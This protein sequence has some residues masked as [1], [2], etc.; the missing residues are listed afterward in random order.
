MRILYSTDA[1]V[2]R[3]KPLA[4][5]I[6]KNE[7]DLK[8][9]ISFAGANQTALIP[10][11]AGTSLAGQCVGNGIVV[12]VSRNFTQ[13]LELNIEEKWVR[14]QPGVIRDELNLYLKPH[15]LMFGPNTS[16]SNRC[17]IGGMVG[18]NSCGSTSIAYGNTRDHLIS[19]KTILSDGSEATFESIDSAS[20]Q[21]KSNQESLEGQLY[22]VVNKMLSE[23]DVCN[24][25]IKEFPKKEVR[26][27]NT[28]YALDELL[29]CELFA[30]SKEQF[31]F[32]KLLAGSEG[33]LAFTTEIKINLVPLPP[34]ISGLICIHFD[35]VDEALQANK[36]AVNHNPQA[37]ELMDR[38]ILDCTIGHIQYEKYRFFLE[39]EPEAILAVELAANTESELEN[40]CNA[41]VEELEEADLG[42]LYPIL[43]EDDI[44]KVWALRKAGLGLLS[45]LPGD[46]KAVAFVEDTAVPV[47]DLPEYIEDFT[48]ML[49]KHGLK[50]VY[51]AHAGAGELHLR[52]FLNLK[53]KKDR[54]L[55]RTVGRETAELV[56]KYGGAN[57]GEHGDGRVRGEFLE[58]L[59]GENN[60]QLFKDI[61]AA[62]DP[63]NIF[64]PGKIVDVPPINENLRYEEDQET[65][66]FDTAFDFSETD[67]IL[68]MTEKCTGSGDCRKTQL[69]GGTMCPSY[70]VT[71][72]EKDTTRGRANILR[73]FLTR[74]ENENPFAH[75][76]V[77]DVMD[78]CLS[79]KG[80]KSECPS[81]VDMSLLKAEFQH[82][83]Y[84]THGVPKRAKAFAN[85][86]KLHKLGSILP[87]INNLGIK[88]FGG[89]AKSQL[90]IAKERSIPKLHSFT[91][92]KWYNKNHKKLNS[93]SSKGKVYFF[94]DEFTNY[95]DTEIG[96]KAI[97][98][99]CKLGYEVIIPEHYESG[100]A[101]FSKG[102]LDDAKELAQLNF[103]ALHDIISE[104]TPLVGVEPSAILGFRDE[105]PKLVK[106][107][108]QEASKALGKNALMLEEF[109]WREVE[110][111]NIS[112]KDFKQEKKHILLHGHCHQKALSSADFSAW[113]L[114]IPEN[115]FV[116]VI[117]SGCCGMAGSFGYEEEHYDISM[118]VGELVLFPAVR[119]AKGA[120]IIAAP[121]TS[122]RH[123]IKDGTQKESFHPIEI[124]FD[125][126]K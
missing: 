45:N 59:V 21:E 27:R 24:E 105:F 79:C 9:L 85:I 5:A 97:R 28:G 62:F 50:S 88:I 65:R 11:A 116:E 94:N 57:S 15:G 17:M 42:F 115:Y 60:Y 46:A 90:G 25:I 107:G 16:T 34:A 84:K 40:L 82:Q 106:K 26:R 30:D 87:G 37:I 112:P 49:D 80:C 69:S 4:V 63:Q 99:L 86:S 113:V 126:L 71:R 76:E 14:V 68:R 38:E 54:E 18:N 64:N 23:S 67:G 72:D 3:E 81:N 93:N 53:E 8:K 66:Q 100:R 117:P 98:L 104:E 120:T 20:F 35:S 36:I 1:S 123:Q 114:G 6:P 19:L 48:S 89:L 10:R 108:Q 43:R 102:L 111:G 91:L 121:G 41:L 32:C 44:Q 75:P 124:L 52:P 73:E 31:N 39:D 103:D 56:K 78:L 13:I 7:S 83:Y 55:F 29:E 101:Q 47:E 22:K 92:N 122:C 70:M 95:L 119:E 2:Y 74:S 110:K 58:M 61:K 12:D 125:A 109:I 33:T 77:K 118:K 51:Y 96:V